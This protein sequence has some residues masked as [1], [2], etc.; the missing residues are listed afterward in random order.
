MQSPFEQYDLP[1]NWTPGRVENGLVEFVHAERSLA[2]QIRLVELGSQIADA[3]D[4]RMWVMSCDPGGAATPSD[5]FICSL[6]T[7]QA[8]AA[9]LVSCMEQFDTVIEY[10]GGATGEELDVDAVL[11]ELTVR[12]SLGGKF[13]R[14]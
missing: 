6:T 12:D 10:A 7:W 4:Q 2:V 5:T 3:P 14:A 11:G 8:A 1:P 9:A 13:D